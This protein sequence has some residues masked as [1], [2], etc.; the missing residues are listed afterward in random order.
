VNRKNGIAQRF[1]ESLGL[2]GADTYE[3]ELDLN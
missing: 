3:Y 1:H 2:E